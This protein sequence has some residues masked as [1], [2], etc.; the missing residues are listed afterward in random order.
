MRGERLNQD[1]DWPTA[2]GN[3]AALVEVSGWRRRWRAAGHDPSFQTTK[4]RLSREHE[5]IG[6]DVKMRET[7]TNANAFPTEEE[8]ERGQERGDEKEGGMNFSIPQ[9]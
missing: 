9:R 8:E 6:T 2:S 1:A 5:M 4:I 7:L 3:E